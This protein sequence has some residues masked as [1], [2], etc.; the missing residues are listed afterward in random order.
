M[1]TA[2]EKPHVVFGTNWLATAT[3][4]GFYQAAATGLYQK[5]G[6]DVEI[7]QGG[8][9][10]N[11]LQLLLTGK[12]DFYLGD[13]IQTIQSVHQGAPLVTVAAAFQKHPRSSFAIRTCHP[14]PMPRDIRC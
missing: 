3:T 9:Q 10:I 5:H 11:G 12:I 6:L 1:A 2:D 14:W 8:P 4:G 13:P 7:K